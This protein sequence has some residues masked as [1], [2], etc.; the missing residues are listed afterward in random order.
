LRFENSVIDALDEVMPE[1]MGRVELHVRA[2]L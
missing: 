1:I 2:A